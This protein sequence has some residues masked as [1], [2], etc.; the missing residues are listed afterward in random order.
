MDE[1]IE[2]VDQGIS[3]GPTGESGVIT[4]FFGTG[5]PPVQDKIPEGSIYN[6]INN[7]I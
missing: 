3:P 2:I 5:S 7:I 1:I 6:I 4:V